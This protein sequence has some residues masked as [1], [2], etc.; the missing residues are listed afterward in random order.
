MSIAARAE[1]TTRA[2]TIIDYHTRRRRARQVKDGELPTSVTRATRTQPD[3]AIGC[4]TYS[5]RAETAEG[6]VDTSVQR[7]KIPD[8]WRE[9]IAAY[10]PS[11]EG[12][13]EYERQRHNCTCPFGKRKRRACPE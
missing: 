13:L 1:A 8:E 3:G 6:Q 10:Y 4:A 7:L 9:R 11:D 2:V 5:V 12:M